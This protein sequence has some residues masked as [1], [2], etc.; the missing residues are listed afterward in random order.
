MGTALGDPGP[1]DRCV[2]IAADFDRAADFTKQAG[3]TPDFWREIGTEEKLL[4]VDF[5]QRSPL[6]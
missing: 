5:L 3:S 1:R 2:V 4:P 6:Y